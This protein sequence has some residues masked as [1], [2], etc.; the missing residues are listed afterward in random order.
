MSTN[1]INIRQIIEDIQSGM[2]NKTLMQK[3]QLSAH[4]LG[5]VI[6]KIAEKGLL[7]REDMDEWKPVTE[8]PTVMSWKCPA[9]H[10]PQPDEFE[11]CPQCGVI[12]SK[13]PAHQRA[14]LKEQENVKTDET[15]IP[16]KSSEP[17]PVII[18]HDLSYTV[19]DFK[20]RRIA[21]VVG[22]VCAVIYLLV[23]TNPPTSGLLWLFLSV[24]FSIYGCY[25]LAQIKGLDRGWGLLAGLMP[26]IG[27]LILI[28]SPPSKKGAEAWRATLERTVSDVSYEEIINL[29]DP[30]ANLTTA[31]RHDQWER[32]E[33]RWVKWTGKVVDVDPKGS[34]LEIS[35]RQGESFTLFLSRFSTKNTKLLRRGEEIQVIGR[36]SKARRFDSGGDEYLLRD[37]FIL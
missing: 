5:A 24:G 33:N 20:K 13:F 32:L 21:G 37:G 17:S 3:Y 31:Q 30:K 22:I 12:V 8:E 9:C 25:G 19:A 6:D 18:Q 36:I 23:R 28:L 27:F 29:V 26:P 2:D 1:H 16:E 35:M 11:V 15:E 14:K 10:I 34:R 7:R 4:Q